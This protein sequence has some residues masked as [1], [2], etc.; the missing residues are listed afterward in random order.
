M[1]DILEMEQL[2]ARDYFVELEHSVAEGCDILAPLFPASLTQMPGFLAGL[3]CTQNIRAK[4]CRSWLGF[5]AARLSELAAAGAF[6]GG[7]C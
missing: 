1:E 2:L 4:S 6:G 7:Q 5:D 3:R